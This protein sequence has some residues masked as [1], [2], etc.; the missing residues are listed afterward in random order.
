MSDLLV[1]NYNSNNVNDT[2]HAY[3]SCSTVTPTPQTIQTNYASNV[4]LET[5]PD[6]FELSAESKIRGK[7]NNNKDKGMSTGLKWLLGIVGTATAVYGAVVGHRALTKP[8]IE[9]V[10]QNFSEIFRKDI[11]KEEAEKLVNNYKEIFKIDNVDD[12]CTKIFEQVKKDYG[13]GNIN[14]K[15]QIEKMADTSV[16]SKM[17]K[18]EMA[19]YNAQCGILKLNPSHFKDNKM[20]TDDKLEMFK[21]VIH[22]LQHAKQSEIAYRTNL[23]KY[24]EAMQQRCNNTTKNFVPDMIN[25]FEEVLKSKY[26]ISQ[27]MKQNN[28]KTV[29]EAKSRIE[30]LI[31]T[32][33]EKEEALSNGTKVTINRNEIKQTLDNLWGKLEKFKEGSKEYDLGLKYIDN[34]ANYINATQKNYDKYRNQLVELEAFGTEPKA[35]EIFNY[36]GNIWRLF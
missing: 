33:K 14:I 12:F 4:S 10:A 8:S 35:Q 3:R 9:K 18:S 30:D 26:E 1:T 17:S 24:L 27:F 13:F 11:S 5:P 19:A 15:L 32:L 31:K 36:F 23:I 2:L 25:H 34:E 6:T 21:S 29:E 7:S 16:A 28:L 22:E 20:C